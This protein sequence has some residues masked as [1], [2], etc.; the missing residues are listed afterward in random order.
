MGPVRLVHMDVDAAGVAAGSDLYAAAPI[1][2]PH[3]GHLLAVNPELRPRALPLDPLAD[4]TAADFVFG[5]ACHPVRQLG[6]KRLCVTELGT[7]AMAERMEQAVP[8]FWNRHPCA[9]A[10]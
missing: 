4:G 3:G 6:P 8:I 9:S 7:S 2:S 1:A 5:V 10:M